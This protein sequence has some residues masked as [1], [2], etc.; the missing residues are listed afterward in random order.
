MKKMT[1]NSSPNP[2]ET[3]PNGTAVRVLKSMRKIIR[4][5]DLHSHKLNLEYHVTV[6][7]MVCIQALIDAGGSMMCSALAKEVE[8]SG[9][10]VNG[11]IDR[12]ETKGL[13]TR[14]RDHIDRRKVFVQVTEEGKALV[15]TVPS[16]LQDRLSEAL[17]MLP[18]AEQ[19]NIALTLE[20]IVTL[21]DVQN[22]DAAPHLL[23]T[24]QFIE[25]QKDLV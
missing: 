12:L 13:T 20:R 9:S 11:I 5:V 25:E 1:D 17:R 19:T 3:H 18:N 16:L 8:L 4:A 6:P 10:T 2:E 23:P 7:Q 24:A 22:L 14:R 21:M 15:K